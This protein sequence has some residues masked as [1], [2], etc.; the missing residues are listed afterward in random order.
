M[1]ET[2][3]VRPA[4]LNSVAP[5]AAVPNFGP[6]VSG[7]DTLIR[8]Q[9]AFE[10]SEFNLEM[11]ELEQQAR[12]DSAETA[13]RNRLL[14][15]SL[16]EQ[17]DAARELEARERRDASFRA[18]SAF[19]D[20]VLAQKVGA[21]EALRAASPGAPGYSNSVLEAWDEQFS[22][23]L[24]TV[25]EE[26]QAEFHMRGRA[27][28]A[29]FA[30]NAMQMQYKLQDEFWAASI[31]SEADKV[32]GQV[33]LGDMPPE[34]AKAQLGEL[35]AES[36][37]PE[38]VKQGQVEA[39]AEMIETAAFVAET[40]EILKSIAGET[41][42]PSGEFT[43][44]VDLPE[45]AVHFLNATAAVESPG[46]NVLHGGDEFFD[47]SDHPNISVDTGEVDEDG[48]PIKSTAAGRYQFLYGTWKEAQEALSLPDFSP[49]NQ[50]RAAWWLAQRDY[51]KNTGRDLLTDLASEDFEAVRKGLETTWRGLADNSKKFLAAL[52]SD[53]RQL[54]IP[55][56]D[57]AYSNI[58]TEKKVRLV[59]D[60]Q[61]QAAA[62]ANKA[63]QDINE[64]Y[65]TEVQNL[66]LGIAQGDFGENEIAEWDED[67]R[68]R[69]V[70]DRNAAISQLNAVTKK[71]TTLEKAQ[72]ALQNP[73]KIWDYGGE[74]TSML[75]ALYDAKGAK[76]VEERNFEDSIRSVMAIA[77]VTKRVPPDALKDLEV[78]M[79]SS[80]ARDV[81]FS[82]ELLSVL[83]EAAPHAVEA[84][85]KDSDLETLEWWRIQKQYFTP[86]EMVEKLR[87]QRS[88]DWMR[89]EKQYEPQLKAYFA[90]FTPTVV[91]RE[92]A[93]WLIP[94]DR[95]ENPLAPALQALL[96]EEYRS[97]FSTALIMHAGDEDRAHE[98]TMRRLM[99]KWGVSRVGGRKSIM[100]NPPSESIGYPAI[101]GRHDWVD[102][103]V[104]A[105][106]G[107][108][109]NHIFQLI[110]DAQTDSEILAWRKA[111]AE[112]DEK[113]MAL[114]P[115]YR[116]EVLDENENMVFNDLYYR[117]RWHGRFGGEIV[118]RHLRNVMRDTF[119]PKRLRE[120][121]VF[122]PLEKGEFLRNADGSISTELTTTETLEDG[123]VINVPTVWMTPS[124][125]RRLSPEESL[126][127]ALKFEERGRKRF[128]RFNSVDEA[129]A[130]AK[131]RSE[132]GGVS[133]GPLFEDDK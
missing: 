87:V 120:E 73:D 53:A 97:L 128:P 18:T 48:K 62:A 43:M 66:L 3:T 100:K 51:K 79:R 104:R 124:G 45:L 96:L 41:G 8:G 36:G 52:G 126:D 125:I 39:A 107:I 117:K 34:V 28:R 10:E 80:D 14:S 17:E 1:A 76:A 77:A 132:Q 109:E 69:R 16:R 19:S 122:R 26:L 37:L 94:Q 54:V 68:W 40:E 91:T 116:M 49:A 25:P 12:R 11:A 95:P 98:Q 115:S 60:V 56:D 85:I 129:V 106:Y 15:K 84:G 31:A 123:T 102:E 127:M 22:S 50:D 33:R 61:R 44:A 113:G 70:E 64:R 101:E 72:I 63:A 4:L 46:Y 24:T 7:L 82:M 29:D 75:N 27:A 110:S 58:P 5:R 20:F 118:E 112:G 23:F 38:S 86:T 13:A 93:S 83:A 103:Q 42:I 111:V 65:R 67:D 9:R 2:P 114:L 78:L 30:L 89:L 121:T 71:L 74:S 90:N 88:D 59:A 99:R 21:Q 55:V 108:P 130:A 6:I 32:L 131:R 119:P 105:D 35:I 57:P 47:F 133:L 81:E 92:F